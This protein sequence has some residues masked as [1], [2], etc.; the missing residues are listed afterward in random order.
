MAEVLG[1][2]AASFQLADCCIGI[3]KLVN[4]ISTISSTLLQYQDLLEELK[5][6]SESIIEK[7]TFQ[8]PHICS[9]VKSILNT[10]RKI[11]NLEALSTRPHIL[12]VLVFFTEKQHILETFEIIEKKKCSLVLHMQLIQLDMLD[13][14]RSQF[15]GLKT[16]HQ[17]KGKSGK[18]V[19]A[20][21]EAQLPPSTS[22]QTLIASVTTTRPPPTTAEMAL[23]PGYNTQSPGSRSSGSMVETSTALMTMPLPASV[24]V[25]FTSEF[26]TQSPDIH[27]P[28][29]MAEDKKEEDNKQEY[30]G[31]TYDLRIDGN[32]LTGNGNQILGFDADGLQTIPKLSS[33]SSPTL[34]DN[35]RTMPGAL[36]EQVLG[37]KIQ[38]RQSHD[39]KQLDLSG[40]LPVRGRITNNTHGGDG[41]QHMGICI[42]VT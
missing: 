18:N 37:T 13:E 3:L 24:E 12:Q 19:P 28:A 31:V 20:K 42:K 38:V 21:L 35:N 22:N 16:K 34:Y 15:R 5:G 32:V 39:G 4:T 27:S 25:A 6:L 41:K 7:K 14:I 9:L 29:S 36:G 23:T 17:K 40:V 2:I 26:N 10:I 11:T 33:A 8:T 30:E 1:T